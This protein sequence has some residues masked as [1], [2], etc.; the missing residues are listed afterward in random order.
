MQRKMH[1]FAL[2]GSWAVAP[3]G[4]DAWSMEESATAPMEDPIP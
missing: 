3:G 2:A 4:W 1:A